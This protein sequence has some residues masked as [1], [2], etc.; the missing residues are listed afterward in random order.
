MP[1]E[2]DTSEIEQIVGSFAAAARRCVSAG[3]DVVELHAAHGYLIH[4]FMSPKTNKRTD[5]YA[6]PVA[7][8][9]DVLEAVRDA[10]PDCT[11]FIPLSA[12]EGGEGGLGES[13]D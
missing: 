5:E 8:A 13:A 11:L 12:F 10:V 3:V 9:N 6:D 1:R 2:L 4:E 7:F